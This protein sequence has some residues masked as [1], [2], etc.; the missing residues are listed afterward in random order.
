MITVVLCMANP[1]IYHV[2]ALTIPS[3]FHSVAP[4]W[5]RAQH[6]SGLFASSIDWH[7]E[8]S[9]GCIVMMQF[10]LCSKQLVTN[11]N[12]NIY[13]ELCYEVWNVPF[14]YNLRSNT[15]IFSKVSAPTKGRVSA[16]YCVLLLALGCCS[17]SARFFL[18]LEDCLLSFGCISLK[19]LQL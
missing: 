14:R 2:V 16:C 8:S 10:K 3:S 4:K 9:Q 19:P 12:S 6:E 1:C 13:P 11:Y 17:K 18:Y 15:T 5:P 7:N